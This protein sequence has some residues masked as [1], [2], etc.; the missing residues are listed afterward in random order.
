ML[1]HQ[2]AQ[3]GRRRNRGRWEM[4]LIVIGYQPADAVNQPRQRV[5]FIGRPRVQ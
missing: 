4:L 5:F 1:F 2:L 3:R